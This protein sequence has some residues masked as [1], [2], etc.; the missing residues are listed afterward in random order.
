MRWP[1]TAQAVV[2]AREILENCLLSG[3]SGDFYGLCTRPQPNLAE[4][5]DNG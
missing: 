1:H 5:R 4:T 2:V 3:V